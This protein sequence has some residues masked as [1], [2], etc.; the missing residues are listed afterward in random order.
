VEWKRDQLIR[1][2][3]S[4]S[5]GAGSRRSGNLI[6]RAIP[7][8]ATQVAEVKT[9]ASTSSAKSPRTRPRA[10]DPSAGLHLLDADPARP[11][12]QPG[13]AR[14]PVRQEGARQAANYAIDK[15][16][17]IQKMMA[18]SAPGRHR[19]A[20]PAFGFDPRSSPIP[21][22][23]RRPRSSWPRPGTPTGGHH[24]AQ[25]ERRVPPGVRGLG[26]DADRGRYPHDPAHVDPGPAWNK[27]L[28]AEA[29]PPRGPT[30]PGGNYSVFDADACCTR[31]TTTSG[32]LDR[33]W[34]ARVEG[35]DKLID[36]ARST[37][38]Q[39]KRK[40]IYSQIQQMIREEARASS[41]SR[42][43]TRSASRRRCSTRPG[44]RVALALRC[45]AGRR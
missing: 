17:I 6:F 43:T 4:T 45:Q 38:D 33:P 2:E 26:R 25:R 14:G 30:G 40:R 9:A 13:H 16:A 42:S 10:Q 31:S 29:R 12:R 36:E 15:S 23:R 1:L 11:L 18:G 27:F 32:R 44:R 37:V 19:R 7:E 21:S 22:T 34:F 8:T 28:Q 41:C 5:T 20:A 3:R 35:L 39:P 24:A